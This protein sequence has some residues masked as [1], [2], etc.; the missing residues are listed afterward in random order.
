MTNEIWR[1]TNLSLD[2]VQNTSNWELVTDDAV[3][4]FEGPSLTKYNGTYY[5][6][7]DKLKDYP[8]ENADGKAGV[9]VLSLIHI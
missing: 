5:M 3:T 2:A 7:T 4:G 6:Y 9:Y 1:T 8:P